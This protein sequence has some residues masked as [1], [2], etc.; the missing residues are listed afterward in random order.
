MTVQQQL[1]SHRLPWQVT[2]K[3]AW[4]RTHQNLPVSA[5]TR[6][7]PLREFQLVSGT[8]RGPAP[9]RFVLENPGLPAAG[10]VMYEAGMR[11]LRAAV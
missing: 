2:R 8:A 9:L 6:S 1:K 10:G 5:S 7:C 4:D 11:A 3:G